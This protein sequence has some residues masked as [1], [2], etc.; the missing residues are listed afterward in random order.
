MSKDEK[1]SKTEKNSVDVTIE[2]QGETE[3]KRE[4]KVVLITKSTNSKS[5]KKTKAVSS[6][7][8]ET[9]SSKLIK[10]TKLTVAKSSN[11]FTSDKK[12]K[13]IEKSATKVNERI[14]IKLKAY[15]SS[16]LDTTIKQIVNYVFRTGARISGPILLPVRKKKFTVNISP[17]V[18]KDARDQYEIRTHKRLIDIIEPTDKTV[19]ALM[20]LNIAA[21]INVEIEVDK[22]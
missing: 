12:R 16:L 5:V 21:G 10:K 4:R 13:S 11:A 17:H 7:K 2:S 15:D 22:I 1:S 6:M 19:N 8:P 3:K 14:R 20:S 9:T 18:D